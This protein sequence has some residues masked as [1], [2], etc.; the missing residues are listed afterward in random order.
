[1]EY[2][3]PSEM[4]HEVTTGLLKFQYS[5]EAKTEGKKFLELHQ[6]WKKAIVDLEEIKALGSLNNSVIIEEIS[7]KLPRTFS[8]DTSCLKTR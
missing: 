1:M 6:I 2:G 8:R 4:T 7:H 3:N 5:R